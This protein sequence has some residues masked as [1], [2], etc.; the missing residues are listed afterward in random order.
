MTDIPGGRFRSSSG[1]LHPIVSLDRSWTALQCPD[2][3]QQHEEHIE[4]SLVEEFSTIIPDQCE[5]LPF[6]NH[7]K[8][9]LH[10]SKKDSIVTV[11]CIDG[12][13]D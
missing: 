7:E 1:W 8:D 5:A 12:S 13:Q 9:Q 11:R 4:Q 2:G 10:R 6:Q 3:R